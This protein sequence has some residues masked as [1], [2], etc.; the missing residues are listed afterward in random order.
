MKA[1]ILTAAI[2]FMAMTSFSQDSNNLFV[3][4]APTKEW[5][6]IEGEN[7]NLAVMQD[8]DDKYIVN[9][10][11]EMLMEDSIR[12]DRPMSETIYKPGIYSLEWEYVQLSN[13]KTLYI[14][15]SKEERYSMITFQEEE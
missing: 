15:Y 11:T 6:M 14:T 3:L 9:Y 8:N 2:S 7:Y 1:I 13:K 4:G 12:F 5:F 10:L